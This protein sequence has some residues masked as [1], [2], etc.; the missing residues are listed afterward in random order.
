[1]LLNR[2]L[3]VVIVRLFFGAAWLTLGRAHTSV[4]STDREGL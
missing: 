1:M 4:E 2:T 3:L